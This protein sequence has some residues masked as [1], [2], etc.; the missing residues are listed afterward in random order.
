MSAS[1]FEA[2]RSRSRGW[3]KVGDAAKPKRVVVIKPK[4]E[5]ADG[6]LGIE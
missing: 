1:D 4:H 6:G 3:E 2:I 5:A